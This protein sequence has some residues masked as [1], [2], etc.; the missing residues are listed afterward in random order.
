[1][2]GKFAAD[3][4]FMVKLLVKSLPFTDT[5][6]VAVELD[7]EGLSVKTWFPSAGL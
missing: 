6:V 2:S 7:A 5:L 1:M 4:T 3:T